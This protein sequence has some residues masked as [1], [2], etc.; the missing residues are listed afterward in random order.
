M[1]I[2]VILP[3]GFDEEKGSVVSYQGVRANA[4]AAEAAGLDSVWIYDHLIYRFEGKPE[5]GVQ[6]AWTF[7]SALAEAT[8]R[9]ELGAL[10]LCVPFRNPAIL[11]K[12]AVTLD[13]LSGHRLILGVGAGWH[14][15]EFDAFGLPFDHL[16]GRFEEAMQIIPPLVR[17]ESVTFSGDYYSVNNVVMNPPSTREGGV[18]VLVASFG[19]R[20]LKLTAQYADQWNT[21]WLGDPAGLDSRLKQMDDA[22]AAV[23]RD[24]KTLVKTVGIVCRFTDLSPLAEGEETKPERVTYGGEDEIAA[25]LAGYRERGV[26]HIIAQIDPLTPETIARFAEASRRAQGQNP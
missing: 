26:D 20:M 17:N 22:C 7:L 11:A 25:A 10:V 3:L 4:V 9:V 21:A 15:P 23:G 19:P 6:E 5:M 14:Q 13:E 1:K 8:N 16:V 24:P 2:G 12:M 18:P